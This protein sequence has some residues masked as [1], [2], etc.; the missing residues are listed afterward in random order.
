[1]SYTVTANQRLFTVVDDLTDVFQVVVTGRVTSAEWNTSLAAF[2]I[3]VDHPDVFVKTFPTGYFALAGKIP[4][5]FPQLATQAYTLQ[6]TVSA[7]GHEGTTLTV[8]VP[9]ASTFPLAEQNFPLNFTPIRIQGRVTLAATGTPVVSAVVRV[10]EANLSTLRT[11]TRFAHANGTPV[12]SGALNPSG[13]LR[14]VIESAPP[15]AQQLRL[16]DTTGL[17]GGSI[18]RLGSATGYTFVVLD[19]L[20]QPGTV[21]LRGTPRRSVNFGEEAR[22]VTFAPDGGSQQLTADVPAGIGLLPLDGTLGSDALEIA[23]ADPLRVEYHAV[24]AITDTQGYYRLSGV[25]R[26]QGV[27]LRAVDAPALNDAERD[28]L[29]DPHQPIN[30]VN[31]SLTPI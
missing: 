15:D 26:R 17:A 28:W 27:H 31:F 21:L 29:I 22:L 20:P 16:S 7:P 1:M 5:L 30:T 2:Q 6:I 23:D 11:P 8:N 9:I 18:L 12:N 14:T 3:E 25:G 24:S 4:V 19:S 10:D 13:A